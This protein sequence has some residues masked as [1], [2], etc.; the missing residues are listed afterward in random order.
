MKKQK[1]SLKDLT[2]KS[3]ITEMESKSKETVKGGTFLRS[4][5][6]A[7]DDPYTKGPNCPL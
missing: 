1:L 6:L 2:V 3:F 7:C 4:V 5:C